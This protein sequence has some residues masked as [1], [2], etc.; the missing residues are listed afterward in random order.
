[1]PRSAGAVRLR[2]AAAVRCEDC[3]DE[4]DPQDGCLCDGHAY[5]PACLTNCPACSAQIEDD[6]AA[7]LAMDER[8]G[9]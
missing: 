7:E 3:G 6:A 2:R 5:C 1:M 9:L 4:F 8:R